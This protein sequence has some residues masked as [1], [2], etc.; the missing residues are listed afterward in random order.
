[1][2]L[3]GTGDSCVGTCESLVIPS[4]RQSLLLGEVVLLDAALA[5]QMA[6]A[7][8]GQVLFGECSGRV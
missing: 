6:G 5:L 8:S 3:V 2:T 7:S 1:M 4:P